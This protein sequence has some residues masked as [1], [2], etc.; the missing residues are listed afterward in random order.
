MSTRRRSS[1]LDRV[2]V[3]ATIGLLAG[4]LGGLAVG[5]VSQKASS[6]SSTTSASH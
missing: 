5:L 1:L 2:S 4:V 3:L 6:G